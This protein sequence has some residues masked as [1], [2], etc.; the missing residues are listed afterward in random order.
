MT[1]SGDD[2]RAECI[3]PVQ[4]SLRTN[5]LVIV[6]SPAEE[7]AV[8]ERFANSPE[9]LSAAVPVL[10]IGDLPDQL[11]RALSLANVA[12]R[13]IPWRELALGGAGVP[14]ANSS[15]RP[16]EVFVTTGVDRQLGT[17]AAALCATQPLRVA[18]ARTTSALRE[19]GVILTNSLRPSGE[20]LELLEL[21]A[22]RACNVGIIDCSDPVSGRLSILKTLLISEIDYEGRMAV[23][24]GTYEP[25]AGER[26]PNWLR[27]TRVAPADPRSP[28]DLL[29]ASGHSNALDAS[30]GSE[31]ALCSRTTVSELRSDAGVFPCFRDGI[32]FR[33][34][35][36][37]IGGPLRLL[38]PLDILS[39]IAVLSG[40]NY[41]PLDRSW[42][43]PAYGMAWQLSRAAAPLAIVASAAVM[44]NVFEIELLMAGLL[45]DGMPIAAAMDR[46]NDV[47]RQV[48]RHAS[49][50]PSE[51]GPYVLLGNPCLSFRSSKTPIK[52][53]LDSDTHGVM[54]HM[55]WSRANTTEG[56]LV[57]VSG[58][59]PQTTGAPLAIT[60][61]DSAAWVRGSIAGRSDPATLY[62]FVI[63]GARHRAAV[64]VAV[65]P[66]GANIQ[67]LR[68]QLGHAAKQAV[69]WTLFLDYYLA[70]PPF[71]RDD[72]AVRVA[73]A[74]LPQQLRSITRCMT[75]LPDTDLILRWSRRS[76]GACV[77]LAKHVLDS[78]SAM[79]LEA[80][81]EIASRGNIR[82]FSLAGML[83]KRKD[84]RHGQC[85]CGAA[86]V[87]GRRY[88]IGATNAV[89]T[90]YHCPLCGPVGEDDGRRT[91]VMQ[92]CE[93]GRGAYR[94][95]HVE[96]Q[97]AAPEQEDLLVFS[98]ALVEDW[99]KKQRLASCLQRTRVAAGRATGL[100]LRIDVPASLTR[101]VYPVSLLSI[102]NG[103]LSVATR[104][105]DV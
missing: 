52:S 27:A 7:A 75:A 24:S 74:A 79:L 96:Y 85:L 63:G 43:N 78:Y 39:K 49:G 70:S 48:H 101:G 92:R 90:I 25:R 10:A 36:P 2:L 46:V 95:I 8:L 66:F 54:W 99:L 20:L 21:S 37:R 3:I 77:D 16:S 76:L 30:V 45:F 68:R 12:A 80:C 42:S 13:L 98:V 105:S 51:V 55:P 44:P 17:L 91:V 23:L 11:A 88:R 4:P 84:V 38:R 65:V 86:D 34:P 14:D 83:W 72:T 104:M 89:R 97:C 100:A 82:A 40:C 15:H 81:V 62:A 59:P 87:L 58:F 35:D 69:F 22:Q 47:G 94:R 103:G 6:E 73:A 9:A 33:Q 60:S 67:S 102:S 18:D 1:S 26:A 31:I 56:T 29:I 64:D 19:T 41:L 32:C 93:R 5:S 28:L 53:R 61:S 57:K 71:A 50:L